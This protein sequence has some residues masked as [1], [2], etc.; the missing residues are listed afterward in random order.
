[1]DELS[2]WG[3]QRSHKERNEGGWT[4]SLRGRSDECRPIS[5]L[6]LRSELGTECRGDVGEDGEEDRKDGEHTETLNA[7]LYLY[8]STG[9]ITAQF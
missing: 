1:M 4:L 5:S 7:A 9:P 3:H 2:E 8:P 6:R